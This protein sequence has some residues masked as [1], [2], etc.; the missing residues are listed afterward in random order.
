MAYQWTKTDAAAPERVLLIGL[1]CG[2]YD[3]EASMAELERLT[4][5]AGG[6]VV[7]HTVQKRPAPEGATYIGSGLVESLAEF[8]RQNEVDLTVADGSL[9]PAGKKRYSAEG[10]EGEEKPNYAP[11]APKKNASDYTDDE[12]RTQINRMQMEKQ[13][14]DLAGQTNVREDDP[15]KELK[16]QRERLQL[17]RDV[18]N[19]K[20]EINSGQ[21]FVGSVLSDA[22]KKALTTMATGAMLYMGRQTVKTLFNNPD[23]ANA[24]G[25]GSLDKEEK[26]K[27]D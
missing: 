11:K 19:L 20:K 16:L 1:D 25:K 10:G 14:R 26:K 6:L 27:D 2:D 4:D 18:K 13:Y 21:T 9:T 23:L 3:A 24:V 12:L 7:G 17:Q 22:G 8:C 5:T 15:N